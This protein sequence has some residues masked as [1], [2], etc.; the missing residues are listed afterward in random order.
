[1]GYTV[2]GTVKGEPTTFDLEV[3]SPETSRIKKLVVKRI[4]VL[5]DKIMNNRRAISVAHNDA[6]LER[7]LK[8]KVKN[9]EELAYMKNW[10]DG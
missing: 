6:E 7:C 5:E 1:M 2:T 4:E 9:E 3:E 8:H 10:L